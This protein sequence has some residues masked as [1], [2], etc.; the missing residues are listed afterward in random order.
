MRVERLPDWNRIAW[1][2]ELAGIGFPDE[3]NPA[4][5]REF[6]R[7]STE[8]ASAYLAPRI[9]ELVERLGRDLDALL[10]EN[11]PVDSSL[12]DPPSGS[13]R[14]QAKAAV[15]ESV[16]LG[17][18][19]QFAQ[20]FG[21]EEE[22]NG[23]LFHQVAPKNGRES[24][25]SN[26]GVVPFLPHSDAA[27][28]LRCHRPEFL[29]LFGLLNE[30]AAVT[31]LVSV[32]RIIEN[33]SPSMIDRLCQPIFRQAPPLSFLQGGGDVAAATH[34][35]LEKSGGRWEVAF[36]SART[37]P[38]GMEAAA[39]LDA[40]KTALRMVPATDVTIQPGSL[41]LFSNLR[42]LHSRSAIRGRRWLQRLY[43]RRDLTALYRDSDIAP[44]R[45][46]FTASQ[47]ACENS[48]FV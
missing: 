42:T 36:N 4:E 34:P 38:E 39:A 29:S 14:P 21:F 7:A 31:S 41:L 10:I 26:G 30:R 28:L 8:L 17:V 47:L 3:R 15:S 1:Q 25:Q 9:L 2:D 18:V 11:L 27:F 40:L 13:F 35:V 48:T 12:P 45:L 44:P 20:V 33:I 5:W 19:R 22:E 32:D 43:S 24:T 46:I 16:H 6:D 23:A 37:R